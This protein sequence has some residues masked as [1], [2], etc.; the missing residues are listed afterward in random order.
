[1][2]VHTPKLSE[3]EQAF[4]LRLARESIV[5]AAVSGKDPDVCE[6]DITPAVRALRC[7]FVTLTKTGVL[8][9]CIGN[10]SP[11]D[12]LFQAVIENARGAA[13]RDSR[14][15]PVG[16][17]EVGEL[18]IEITVL[19]KPKAVTS[20][21]P[22]ELM[23]QLRPGIDG[24]ILRNEGQTATFLPQVW[25]KIPKPEEFLKALSQKAGLAEDAWCDPETRL[26][27]YQVESFATAQAG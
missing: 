13:F 4:L 24:V 20:H 25:E 6:Q 1:M 18:Q 26:M 15:E 3:S 14:F 21:D 23:R 27:T 2:R 17:G 16:A 19:E 22:E 11:K 9:G 12:P 8:R 5:V 7:C 10:L